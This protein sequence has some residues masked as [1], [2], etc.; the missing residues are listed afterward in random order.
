MVSFATQGLLM[1]LD[2][3]A[4]AFGW[5]EWPVPQLN[6][7]R[8]A[9]D[10]TCGSGSLFA[11]GLNYSLTGI[12][13]NRELATQIGMSEPPQTLAEFEDLL[14]AAKERQDSYRS[15]SGAVLGAVWDLPSHCRRSWHPSV[16]S[17]RS[18]TGSS[19]NPERRSTRRRTS[20]LPNIWSR[21]IHLQ[22]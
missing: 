20:M 2:D 17:S 16:L 13:Y 6:Q 15:C 18:T 19:K 4:T 9:E 5:D 8:V 1:N 14:A 12:F 7:N 10:G 22:R 21:G 11:M 3:Y